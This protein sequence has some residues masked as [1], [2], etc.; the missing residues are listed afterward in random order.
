MKGSVITIAIS[1]ESEKLLRTLASE[2][3]GHEKGALGKTVSMAIHSLMEK[4]KRK[5]ASDAL[6]ADMAKGFHGG[7]FNGWK[8]RNEIYD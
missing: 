7:G 4:K 1:K 3:F 2:E 6:L 8:N 5:I